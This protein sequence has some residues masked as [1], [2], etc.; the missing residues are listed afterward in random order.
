[1]F[2]AHAPRVPAAAPS[3]PANFLRLFDKISFGEG[4]ENSTRGRVRSPEKANINA[5]RVLG[6][7]WCRQAMGLP[8]NCFL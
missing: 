4:A 3:P 6:E 8:C 2:G 5:S 1:M 7:A